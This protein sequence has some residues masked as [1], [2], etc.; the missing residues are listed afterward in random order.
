MWIALLESFI[1]ER[2]AL[3]ILLA[4]SVF[5]IRYLLKERGKIGRELESV[6]K[7]MRQQMLNQIVKGDVID[8]E[9]W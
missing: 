3:G 2:G 9:Q 4:A 5:I 1:S 6:R 7:E 8:L